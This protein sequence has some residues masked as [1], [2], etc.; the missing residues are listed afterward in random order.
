MASV[1]ATLAIGAL[2]GWKPMMK[3]TA[4]VYIQANTVGPKR[5]ATWVRLPHYVHMA[6]EMVQQERQA[7]LYGPRCPLLQ[8]PLR[9]PRTRRLVG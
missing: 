6:A 3:D 1:R 9:P 5:P 2:R 8:S 7:H 4:Q